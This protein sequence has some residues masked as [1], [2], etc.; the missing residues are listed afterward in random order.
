MCS[1]D[2]L[3]QAAH[4]AFDLSDADTMRIAVDLAAGARS[5]NFYK[6]KIGS[7]HKKS[8]SVLY[9]VRF[10]AGGFSAG[11]GPTYATASI[12]SR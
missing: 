4:L 12:A 9:Q 11:A 10:N 2:L 5:F 8:N 1:S 7:A 3:D 6:A